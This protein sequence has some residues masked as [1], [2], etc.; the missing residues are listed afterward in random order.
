MSKVPRTNESKDRC[1]LR[2]GKRVDR[3][4]ASECW[5]SQTDIEESDV[6][7][8]YHTERGLRKGAGI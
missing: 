3:S 5:Y 2:N 6:Y 8:L 1:E 4:I 7:V